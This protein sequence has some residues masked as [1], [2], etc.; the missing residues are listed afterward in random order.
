MCGISGF[1]HPTQSYTLFP[2]KWE[3]ILSAM[4]HALRRRGPDE[5]GTLLGEHYGL[6][7][8]RLKILDLVTGQQPMY[9]DVNGQRYCIVFNGE[10]YNM[11]ALRRSLQRDGTTFCTTSDTE[12]ILQGYIRYG[13]SYIQELN[14]V[15]AIALYDPVADSLLLFRDRLGVKPLFY[16][17]HEDTLIF[18]S[19][20][21]GLFAYPDIHPQLDQDG[22]CEIFALGPARTPGSAVFHGIHAVLPGH[23]M[24]AD[25]TGVHLSAYWT[26]ESKHHTDSFADTIEH[27]RWL[28]QDAIQLQM[29]SDLPVCTF[30]SGG[31]DSSIVTAI[32]AKEQ[33]KQGCPLHT[34]SF[35]FKENRQYFQANHFQPSEDHPYVRKMITF[36]HTDHTFLTCCSQDQLD[37]LYQAVDA[38]DLPCMAD[39]ES[40]MLF[41]CSQVAKT[42]KVAL[43]G[44]CAD[45]I[46]GG[47]PWFHDPFAF[48]RSAFPWSYDMEP[49]RLLLQ[50]DLAHNL[51]LESYARTAY[52]HS[53]EQAPV[54]LEDS[55]SEKRRR[56][57]S[58]LNLTWFMS[59][60]LER[61]DRTS[62]YSGLE[63]RVPFADHR[64]VE[65]LF[66]VPWEMK[67]PKGITKGLLRYA[68]RD[69]LLD[70][71]LWRPKSPYPKTYDPMYEK[72]LG[73]LLLEVLSD[74]NAPIRTL[75]DAKKVRHF[76]NSPSDYG[77]PWY[78]QLMAGPQMLAYLLQINYWLSHYQIQILSH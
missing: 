30:L 60:L 46:F 25:H 61:M 22:L 57:I 17:Q 67:C 20:L 51:P 66:N 33:K 45:E 65:Y 28:I 77:R 15:F 59:T 63:A 2:K 5:N 73:S 47:Y 58:W 49:R 24:I 62:M 12:V 69:L 43:T 36:A 39:I 27:T 70:D 4:N 11:P 32:C 6:A 10:I 72:S 68:A 78:G 38:R 7:H 1:Y 9:C 50:E 52:E 18:A 8:T 76:L 19:E 55:D 44:E 14:G 26:L 31:I 56:E 23:C 48:Q 40:S 53:I 3:H 34:F 16:A 71:I 64:I 41:F 42:H 37:C 21:K 54:C 29:L 13:A 74:P 35:D 75:I